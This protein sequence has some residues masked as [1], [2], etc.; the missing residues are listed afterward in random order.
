MDLSIKSTAAAVTGLLMATSVLSA[1]AAEDDTW[2]VEFTPYLWAAGIDADVEVR[3]RSGSVDTSFSDILDHLDM[4]AAFL[5]DAHYNAWVVRAQ[6][7]YLELSGDLE[8]G[9]GSL[10]SEMTM[11]TLGFGY[12]FQG[13]KQGQT[14]DVLLG[15]RNLALDN[16]LKLDAFGKFNNDK[17]FTDPIIM[18]Q[19][20]FQLSERWRFNPLFSYGAGGDSEYTYELQPQVQF[21]AWEHVAFRV[22][23]RKLYYKIDSDSGNAFDGSFQGPFIGIGATFG[24]APA[25]VAAAPLEPA[26]APVVAPPRD[27]D[28]DGVPDG[29]DQCPQTPAGQRV[30]A[31]GC[32]YDIHVEALFDSE[33]ATIKPESYAALDRAVDLLKSVPSMR[34]VIEGHTDSTGSAAY[35]QALSER[36]A[37]AVS[38]YLVKHG[39]DAARV[40]SKGLGES[41]AIA[42]N[43]TAEGRAQNRRVV[44]RRAD[45]GS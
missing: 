32:G 39:I 24:G 41:H 9:N 18:V 28:G 7:D 38:D 42:D 40:P 44:L 3:D 8:R 33:S 43:K 20:S 2:T 35:N 27:A 13:W 12:Q 5:A 16:T 14:F 22:G 26:P 36:R 25:P 23:Y 1:S 34:G 6:V 17:D 29:S 31:I 10:D 37:A 19:P 15:V 45:L 11:A 21:Q 4:A 30:D